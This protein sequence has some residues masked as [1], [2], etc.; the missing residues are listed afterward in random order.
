MLL[1]ILIGVAIV[2]FGIGVVVGAV[3]AMLSYAADV[4][5]PDLHHIPSGLACPGAGV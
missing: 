1:M 5:G 2:A 3:W 4:P